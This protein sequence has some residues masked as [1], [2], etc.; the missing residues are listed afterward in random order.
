MAFFADVGSM[1]ADVHVM[2]MILGYKIYSDF[3][4]LVIVVA[5]YKSLTIKQMPVEHRVVALKN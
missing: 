1:Y 5:I 3:M 2:M 4:M